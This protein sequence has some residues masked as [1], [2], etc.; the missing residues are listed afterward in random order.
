MT[1]ADS[2][3]GLSSQ[4]D[5]REWLFVPPGLTLHAHRL[6]AGEWLLLDAVTVIDKSGIGVAHGTVSDEQGQLGLV[7]QPLLI[8]RLAP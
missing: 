5:Q 8:Q 4:L 3:N 1:V 7:A 6:D 2:I